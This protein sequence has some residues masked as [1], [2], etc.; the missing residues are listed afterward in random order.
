MSILTFESNYIIS[1]S[2]QSKV[3]P[4]LRNDKKFAI[5]YNIGH[6][7][8]YVNLSLEFIMDTLSFHLNNI[9]ESFLLESNFVKLRIDLK[10]F[11]SFDLEIFHPAWS[12][13]LSTLFFFKVTSLS[14]DFHVYF[15]NPFQYQAL[16]HDTFFSQKR[17]RIYFRAHRP[18]KQVNSMPSWYLSKKYPMNLWMSF[19]KV[20]YLKWVSYWKFVKHLLNHYEEN[21]LLSKNNRF[22]FDQFYIITKA[23]QKH[24]QEAHKKVSSMKSKAIW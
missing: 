10:N 6:S 1:E 24:K 20:K 17:I 23:P 22:K 13:F 9:F 4:Q 21:I 15:Q 18:I 3:N 2:L 19:V 5:V 16:Q 12:P 8:L 11:K 7:S 14:I